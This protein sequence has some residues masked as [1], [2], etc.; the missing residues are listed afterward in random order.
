MSLYHE[1]QN[2]LA[3]GNRLVITFFPQTECVSF[4]SRGLKDDNQ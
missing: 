2:F 3:R 4:F 1:F